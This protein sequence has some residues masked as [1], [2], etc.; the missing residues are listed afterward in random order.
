MTLEQLDT[1]I[2]AWVW[3]D[4]QVG[5]FGPGI[6]LTAG[7][8]AA[9]R[10]ARGA[11]AYIRYR[12]DVAARRH[13]LAAERQQMH[14]ASHAIDTAPLIPTQPGHDDDLLVECWNAW[15]AEPRKEKP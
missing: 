2:N 6:A 7:V 11:T 8:W 15:T 13:A 14:A 9:Y 10:T 1:A 12:R 3:I 5:T 4:H